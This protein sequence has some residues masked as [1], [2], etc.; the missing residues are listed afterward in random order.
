MDESNSV[1]MLPPEVMPT[2]TELADAEIERIDSYH[3]VYRQTHIEP[4]EPEIPSFFKMMG[5][6]ASIAWLVALAGLLLAALRTGVIFMLAEQLLLQA[7]NLEGDWIN[8]QFPRIIMLCTIFAFEGYLFSAGMAKGKESQEVSVSWLGVAVAGIVSALAN[9]AS[10]LPLVSMDMKSGF[11]LGLN[12]FLVIMT[13]I[14]AT[15]MAYLGAQAIGILSNKRE[16][17]VNAIRQDFIERKNEFLAAMQAEYRSKGRKGIFGE[18]SWRQAT[19]DDVVSD[20][21]ERPAL[22]KR[23]GPTYEDVIRAFLEEKN[24]SISQVG[25]EPGDLMAP[26]EIAKQLGIK[27]NT[28]RSS[29]FRIRK[30]M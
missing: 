28:V 10:S 18:E 11:G 4:Q 12:V 21:E 7:F 17:R 3:R 20:G 13:G 5:L 6:E 1:F 14:G 26:V 27:P 19:R 29:L 23:K 24:L 15:L 8:Q 22:Q 2:A 25:D 16:A 30:S 9:L